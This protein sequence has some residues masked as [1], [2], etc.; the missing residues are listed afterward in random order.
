[1]DNYEIF[2][3]TLFILFIVFIIWIKSW[4]KKNI[5]NG[6]HDEFYENGNLKKLN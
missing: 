1:M 5:N 3:I 2:I 6:E 4:N